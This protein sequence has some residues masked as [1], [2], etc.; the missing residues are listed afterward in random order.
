MIAI[1]D[2]RKAIEQLAEYETNP[3]SRMRC[4]R[5]LRNGTVMERWRMR[6]ERRYEE[7]AGFTVKFGEPVVVTLDF[8]SVFEWLTEHWDEI[9]KILLTILPLFI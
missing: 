2:F 8:D 3:I 7:T 5:A 4:R 6:V 1:E 9:L